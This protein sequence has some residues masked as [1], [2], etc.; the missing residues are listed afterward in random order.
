[1]SECHRERGKREKN[2][3]K[4]ETEN[5]HTC[6]YREYRT[7]DHSCRLTRGRAET[8]TNRT[9]NVGAETKANPLRE[10]THLFVVCVVCCLVFVVLFAVCCVVCCLLFVV[11]FVCCL[12]KMVVCVEHQVLRISS[13]Q[14][15]RTV[16]SKK[17]CVSPKEKQ[18][19]LNRWS[20]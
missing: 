8:K 16:S 15:L 3:E 10:E 4:R 11:C 6:D 14:T 7:M 5:R 19:D 9:V 13:D 12:V 1:M 20:T 2:G 18:L 17:C